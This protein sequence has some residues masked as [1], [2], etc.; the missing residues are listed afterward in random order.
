MKRESRPMGGFFYE[1]GKFY[2]GDIA[3]HIFIRVLF[4]TP[5]EPP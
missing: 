3:L 1:A 4:A 2:P 5:Q